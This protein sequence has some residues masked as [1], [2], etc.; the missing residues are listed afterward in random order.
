MIIVVFEV[1][2][3]E[4]RDQAYFDLAEALRPE[5]ERVDGFVSVERFAP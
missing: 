2:M 5:L 4:R 1:T 3:R